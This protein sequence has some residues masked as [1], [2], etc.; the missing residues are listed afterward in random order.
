[1]KF[2]A[3]LLALCPTVTT[4]AFA[5][6]PLPVGHPQDEGILPNVSSASSISSRVP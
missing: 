1:M 2:I 6:D 5:A 3:S 4:F